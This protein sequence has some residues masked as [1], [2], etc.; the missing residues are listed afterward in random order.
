MKTSSVQVQPNIDQVVVNKAVVNIL[1]SYVGRYLKDQTFR[2]AVMH[3]FSNCFRSK[4]RVSENDGDSILMAK[5]ELGIRYVDEFVEG[6][7][8]GIHYLKESIKL[9]TL[10]ASL[11]SQHCKNRTTCGI[12]NLIL[13]ASAQFYIAVVYKIQKNDGICARYLLRVFCDSPFMARTRLLPCL[14]E[15]LFLPHLLHIKVWYSNEVDLVWNSDECCDKERMV[16][17]LCKVY[18]G[19]M[20]WGTSQ[21]AF[22]Y[23]QLLKVEVGASEPSLPFVPLPVCPGYSLSRTTSSGAVSSISTAKRSL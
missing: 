18:N 21:F 4:I 14:W 5:L 9:L 1:S 17:S 20:D 7:V 19:Q 12:P 3:N 23:K 8:S 2:Q 10:I 13:S 15:Q 11:N 6:Y 22:Y 16:N